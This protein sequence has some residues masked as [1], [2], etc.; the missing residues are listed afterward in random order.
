MGQRHVLVCKSIF[1]IN[2]HFDEKC[3]I[4]TKKVRDFLL[5]YINMME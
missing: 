2:R 4:A 5:N 3:D 1:Q